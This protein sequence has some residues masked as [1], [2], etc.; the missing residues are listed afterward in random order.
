MA[1]AVAMK[2]VEGVTGEWPM[3]SLSRA[4]AIH[5]QRSQYLI[6]VEVR[7]CKGAEHPDSAIKGCQH[8]HP[9]LH[10]SDESG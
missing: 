7:V 5:L 1:T 8:R 4:N 2:M 10:R 9:S 3:G 6:V